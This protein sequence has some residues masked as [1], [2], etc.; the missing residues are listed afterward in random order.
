MSLLVKS[1]YGS[2]KFPEKLEYKEELIKG[3]S[4]KYL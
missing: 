3:L 4:N 1:F 2:F